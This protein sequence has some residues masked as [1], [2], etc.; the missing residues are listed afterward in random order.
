MRT[1]RKFLRSVNYYIQV[2]LLQSIGV[3]AEEMKQNMVVGRV[4]LDK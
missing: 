1:Q 3:R 2:R 4:C